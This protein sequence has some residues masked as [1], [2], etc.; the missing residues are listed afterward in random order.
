M[1]EKIWS[2]KIHVVEQ[3]A[4]ITKICRSIIENIQSDLDQSI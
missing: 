2:V 1:Q 4:T 3:R